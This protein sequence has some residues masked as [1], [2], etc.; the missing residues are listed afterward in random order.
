M[1][2]EMDFCRFEGWWVV[3][4]VV[5]VVVVVDRDGGMDEC[6]FFCLYVGDFLIIEKLLFVVYGWENDGLVRFDGGSC[7]MLLS[8][9]FMWLGIVL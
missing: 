8:L 6:C 1:D 2:V 5:I 9:I 3:V 7:I 4:V